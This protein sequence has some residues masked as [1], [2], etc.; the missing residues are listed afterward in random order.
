[1]YII[2]VNHSGPHNINIG[3]DMPTSPPGV[4]SPSSTFLLANL[5]IWSGIYRLQG[6]SQAHDPWHA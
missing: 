3:T 1:M 2:S 6:V 5:Y 4:T